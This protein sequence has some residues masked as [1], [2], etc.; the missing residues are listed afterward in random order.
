[1]RRLGL[2][3]MIR[4][5]VVE[6]PLAIA[7]THEEG[8]EIDMRRLTGNPDDG[9]TPPEAIKQV[10]IIPRRNR[11]QCLST[12]ATGCQV[13]GATICRGGQKHPTVNPQSRSS[14]MCR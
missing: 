9:H 2:R 4:S 5:K 10:S 13:D 14:T 12:R 6:P 8:Q 1:M 11:R 7:T 3:G